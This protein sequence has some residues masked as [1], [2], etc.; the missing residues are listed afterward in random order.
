MSLAS[1][2]GRR[3]KSRYSHISYLLAKFGFDTAENEPSKICPIA[4]WTPGRRIESLESV[5]DCA[6]RCWSGRRGRIIVGWVRGG[7]EYTAMSARS[8]TTWANCNVH[9]CGTHQSC[10]MYAYFMHYR[11]C[12]NAYVQMCICANVWYFELIIR[13]FWYKLE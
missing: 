7:W 5:L 1:L 8:G 11:M 6:T 13:N 3:K 10:Q 9:T 2:G 4:A 12:I